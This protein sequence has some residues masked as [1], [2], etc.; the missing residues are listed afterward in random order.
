MNWVRMY[1]LPRPSHA[2]HRPGVLGHDDVLQVHRTGLDDDAERAEHQRQLVGDQLAGR[3]QA[4]EQRVLVGAGPA[5]DEDAEDADR[6]HREGV[7]HAGLEVGQPGVR[8]E[9]QAGDEQERRH[10]H[11]QRRHLEDAVVGRRRRG[12][13]LLQPLADLGEQLHRAVRPGLHGPEAALHERHHLEQEEVDDRAGRQ[14]H[15]D[16]PAEHPDQRL[17]P[18]RDLH[19]QRAHATARSVAVFLNC[20]VRRPER[21]RLAEQFGIRRER[22][23]R[24]MS[25]RMK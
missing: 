16:D 23:H 24:S 13:L 6:R 8:A 11:D 25:P 10:Q 1:G 18:V 22:G 7:E 4:A 2:E 17:P 14:Q 21:G 9:R 15:G 5:G 20:S 19:R 12:V 3:P